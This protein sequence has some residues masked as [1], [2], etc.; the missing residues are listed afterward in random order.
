MAT[1]SLSAHNS[2]AIPATS[3]HAC[4]EFRRPQRPM[5][6]LSDCP[7]TTALMNQQ[8]FILALCLLA[9]CGCGRKEASPAAGAPQLT[10]EQTAQIESEYILPEDKAPLAAPRS[11]T[12]P[13]AAIPSPGQP[14]PNVIQ[15]V[16]PIQERINGAI[17]AQLTVQLRMY[18]EKNG[19]MPQTFS[20]FANSAMDSVPLA[21]EGM[22]FAIDPVD[23]TVKVV[24]K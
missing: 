2:A 13:K 7:P 16:R 14:R 5:P 15:P 12:R 23:R 6:C 17:H 9:F 10:P 18:V 11:A 4:N 22:K 1:S 8:V 24:K 20:E 19:R 3:F 21:P